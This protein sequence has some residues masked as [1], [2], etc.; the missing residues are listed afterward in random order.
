[1]L[2]LII[3]AARLARCGLQPA[4]ARRGRFQKSKPRSLSVPPVRRS[5]TISPEAPQ[6]ANHV[7]RSRCRGGA[8]A[9]PGPTGGKPPHADGFLLFNNFEGVSIHAARSAFFSPRVNSFPLNWIASKPQRSLG[10]MPNSMILRCYRL[11][12]VGK[13][14][15]G[16]APTLMQE[17]EQPAK[18]HN[19][20][21]ITRGQSIQRLRVRT[22]ATS[23]CYPVAV[24][25]Q[26]VMD[27]HKTTSS[28]S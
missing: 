13:V 18:S 12:E 2:D 7:K 3:A 27:G 25:K 16:I 20:N 8:T 15:Q 9:L 4:R 11:C 14:D 6:R 22:P 1:M 19:F 17:P 26:R 23:T 24:K 21:L 28:A 5:R 10:I